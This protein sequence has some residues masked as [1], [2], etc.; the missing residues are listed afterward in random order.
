VARRQA[1]A[2]SDDQ[3]DELGLGR[4]FDVERWRLRCERREWCRACSSGWTCGSFFAS[5]REREAGYWAVRDRLFAEEAPGSR[6]VSYWRYEAPAVC[7]HD[8]RCELPAAAD[9]DGRHRWLDRHGELSG[10]ERTVLAQWARL[11]PPVERLDQDVEE[12]ADA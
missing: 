8:P 5:D 6:P 9:H 3:F 2:L 10:R 12:P 1:A 7:R 11:A 4:F